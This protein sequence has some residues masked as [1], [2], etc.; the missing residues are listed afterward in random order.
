LTGENMEERA[1][2]RALPSAICVILVIA[3]FF[4]SLFFAERLLMPKFVSK[5]PEGSLIGDYYK[6]EVYDNKV[7]VL[8]DCEAYEAFQPAL[9]YTRTGMWSFVRGTPSQR[10]WQSYYL[11]ED[12]FKHETPEYMILSVQEMQY[13]DS[14]KEEYNR[15]TLDGMKMSFA[16]LKAIRDSIGKDESFLSYIFPILRYHDRWKELGLEDV[17]YMFAKP[18][19]SERGYMPDYR[20][21][22]MEM[23]P[24]ESPLVLSKLPEKNMVYLQKLADLCKK[25][26]H[27][28]YPLQVSGLISALV[29]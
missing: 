19:V 2:K 22:P 17:K 18:K 26:R 3:L 24:P 6:C 29:Q 11:A 21:Q 16:K 25:K 1:V 28:A 9:F 14:A 8:G 15:M 13:E 27:K 12:T 10:I 7:V 20:V 5:V 4:A 23:L